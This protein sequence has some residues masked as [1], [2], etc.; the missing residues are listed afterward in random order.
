MQT[1]MQRS[2]ISV[3]TIG[4]QG[5]E[6]RN[7]ATDPDKISGDKNAVSENKKLSHRIVACTDVRI[8]KIH[9]AP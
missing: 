5:D 4:T 6:I 1:S 8:Y 7:C 3:E 9:K 2:R